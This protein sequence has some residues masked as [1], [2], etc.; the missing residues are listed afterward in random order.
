MY[1]L[2]WNKALEAESCSLIDRIV[3]QGLEKIQVCL[4]MNKRSIY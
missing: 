2:S 1:L 4:Y 3:A